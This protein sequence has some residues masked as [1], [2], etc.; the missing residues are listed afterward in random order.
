MPALH[1]GAADGHQMALIIC[2]DAGSIEG[3][4]WWASVTRQ[5]QEHQAPAAW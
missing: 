1:F 4:E 2:G 3:K 5:H